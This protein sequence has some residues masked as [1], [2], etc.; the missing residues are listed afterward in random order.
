MIL[1]QMKRL[2]FKREPFCIFRPRAKRSKRFDVRNFA[3]GQF[4]AV[5][6]DVEYAGFAFVNETDGIALLREY[7]GEIVSEIVF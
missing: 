5:I 6:S 2:P 7:D 3:L 4:H 1:L